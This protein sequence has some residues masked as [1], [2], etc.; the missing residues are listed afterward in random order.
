MMCISNDFTD[1]SSVC[2]EVSKLDA[3]VSSQATKKDSQHK[4][5]FEIGRDL[6]METLFAEIYLRQKVP[7]RHNCDTL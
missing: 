2:A 4:N 1:F 3:Q 6:S 7:P 5:V